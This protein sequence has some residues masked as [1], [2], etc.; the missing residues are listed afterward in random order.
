MTDSPICISGSGALARI[1]SLRDQY[2]PKRT[3]LVTGKGSYTNSGAQAVIEAAFD[4]F[5]T[6][7]FSDF[8]VNPKIEDALR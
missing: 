6:I 4:G 8:E 2:N 1:Q 3:L 7:R 5:E